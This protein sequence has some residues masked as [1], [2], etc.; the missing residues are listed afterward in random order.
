[1]TS[2]VYLY[3]F[4][5]I[6][7]ISFGANQLVSSTQDIAKKLNISY[8]VSS[9][10]F[11]GLATSSPEIFISILASL[12]SKTNIAIGNGLG[13]NIA[14]IA[15]VSAFS[16][17]LV[18]FYTKSKTTLTSETKN[19]LKLM[20]I[21]TFILI[22]ILYDGILY[23]YESLLLLIIFG[24][25]I[26]TFRNYFYS[27][28]DDLIIENYKSESSIIKTIFKLIFS[29]TLLLFG[30]N[31]FLDSSIIFAKNIGISD[32]VIG[33][34]LTAIGSSLPELAS[35]IESA[36]KKNIDFII[37]NV[38]GSNIFNIAIVIGIA[39][40]IEPNI[41]SP[42]LYAD[43]MRDMVMILITT[44]AFYI[45]IKSRNNYTNKSL[46]LLLLASFVLY[47]VN[48]YG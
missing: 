23:R 38:L 9:F 40:L 5:S 44:L 17:L 25:S 1:M 13:S 45:I 12:N 46:C 7:L 36:R 31:L 11:I 43:F 10:I 34:S 26:Y 27:N 8:F 4:L 22:P 16:F 15:L 47:Q 48:L 32:Y 21:L 3:F 20:V 39:G 14:N 28:E 18:N 42:L 19:F 29:L 41:F 30:T 37:G 24:L 6:I 35:A 33:L 2:L